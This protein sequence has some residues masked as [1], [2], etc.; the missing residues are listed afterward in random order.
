MRP[1][2]PTRESSSACASGSLRAVEPPAHNLGVRPD[3]F[4]D[5]RHVRPKCERVL[6]P[7]TCTY[8][9][10]VWR[11]VLMAWGQPDIC[12][13]GRFRRLL[14]WSTQISELPGMVSDQERQFRMVLLLTAGIEASEMGCTRSWEPVRGSVDCVHQF[15]HPLRSSRGRPSLPALLRSR[16]RTLRHHRPTRTRRNRSRYPGQMSRRRS[17]T[18][19]RVATSRNSAYARQR[20]RRY[21][22]L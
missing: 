20:H 21:L 14:S 17:T 4:W 9:R 19:R 13:K 1:R 6:Q 15:Q 8:K 12:H 7:V 18:R 16:H 22:Y 11:F 3:P 10:G 5:D 2:Q